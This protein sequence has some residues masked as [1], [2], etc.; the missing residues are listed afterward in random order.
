MLHFETNLVKNN[1]KKL[2]NRRRKIKKLESQNRLK[3]SKKLAQTG[4]ISWGTEDTKH[5]CEGCQFFFSNVRKCLINPILKKTTFSD[6]SC[7]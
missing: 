5:K 4:N 1:K 7:K 2:I 3:N 6:E